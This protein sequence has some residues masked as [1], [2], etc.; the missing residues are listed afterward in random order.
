MRCADAGRT[1]AYTV[2]RTFGIDAGRKALR[3]QQ[4]APSSVLQAPARGGHAERFG[5]RRRRAF[6]T[7][8]NLALPAAFQP[9]HA[10]FMKPSALLA[11]LLL[12]P[13]SLAPAGEVRAFGPAPSTA[14]PQTEASA[15]V[16]A[17]SWRWPLAP[18]PN[19]LR[20]FDPPPKP[21][22]S[23]HRGVDLGAV[24]DG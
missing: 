2:G 13:A 17:P 21:W 8:G 4:T 19:V 18:R 10:G 1:G 20:D 7:Y 5:R 14:A 24:S 3:A 11:A 16:A 15:N 6:S 12:L 9:A 22:L 23:G